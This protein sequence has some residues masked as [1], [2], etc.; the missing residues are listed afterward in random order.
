[1]FGDY[2]SGLPIGVV[3]NPASPPPN[4]VRAWHCYRAYGAALHPFVDLRRI[5]LTHAKHVPRG[6]FW[7]CPAVDEDAH[8]VPGKKH[9]LYLHYL[10]GTHLPEEQ[11]AVVSP[12]INVSNVGTRV[13]TDF[14]SA[15][16]TGAITIFIM[17]S[18]QWSSSAFLGR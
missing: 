1:M 2:V 17:K 14:L 9:V 3:V 5:V 8:H 11:P 16:L 10:S 7:M 18:S 4:P 6:I 13:D 15:R 12:L